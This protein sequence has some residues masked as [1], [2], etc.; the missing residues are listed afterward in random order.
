MRNTS[1]CVIP[2]HSR[3]FA[4]GLESQIAGRYGYSIPVKLYTSETDQGEKAEDFKDASKAWDNT[5]AVIYTGTVSV[6]IS[7][8]VATQ[9]LLA[10]TFL[11][12]RGIQITSLG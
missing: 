6:G 8:V 9:H 2:C 12:H 4:E 10:A 5:R 11:A 1:G 7:A 3:K